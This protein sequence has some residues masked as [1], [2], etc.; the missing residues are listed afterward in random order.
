MEVHHHPQL[1][2]GEGKKIKEYL[3]EGLMIFLAVFMGFVA[4]NIREHLSDS[5]KEKKY[6]KSLYSDLKK[7]SAQLAEVID[8][9]GKLNRGQ[10]SL[11]NLLKQSNPDRKQTNEIYR[12]FFKYASV[13]PDFNSTERTMS[14]LISSGSFRLI[15]KQDIAD[16]ISSY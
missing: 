9:G 14:Q 7:D 15:A 1:P 10:D 16:S 4:E 5:G 3:L 11:L 8:M 2:H 12:L 13:L 6:I